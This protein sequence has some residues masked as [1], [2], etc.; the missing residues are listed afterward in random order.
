M[1]I[2]VQDMIHDAEGNTTRVYIQVNRI[3]D[4]GQLYKIQPTEAYLGIEQGTVSVLFI[5]DLAELLEYDENLSKQA[6]EFA[7]VSLD[8]LEGT[9]EWSVDEERFHTQP[10]VAYSYRNNECSVLPLYEFIEHTT[11]Y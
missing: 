4:V 3:I 5:G 7:R 1:E 11:H 2:R 8:L 6:D 10:W 9:S